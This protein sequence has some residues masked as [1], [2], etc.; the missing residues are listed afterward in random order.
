M[1]IQTTRAAVL[2]ALVTAG[3]AASAGAPPATEPTPAA[4]SATAPSRFTPADV[5]FMTAMIGHHAQAIT[6]A[7]LAPTHGASPTIQTLAARII[8]AQVDEIRLMRQWL[9]DRNQPVPDPAASGDHAHHGTHAMMPG[10]LTEAQL[11]ELD[12]AR[13]KQFD[14]LFLRFMIQHHQGAV[15]MVDDLVKSAGA[16]QDDTTFK[17]VSDINVD[18]ATEIRR[19]QQ[20]LFDLV[21]GKEDQ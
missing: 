9:E 3:C 20:M 2:F 21:I 8:N 11:A 15:T 19:M 16:A 7:K 5:H 17:I 12:A 13:G 14:E 18:Q 1:I 6:M 10:M 4:P